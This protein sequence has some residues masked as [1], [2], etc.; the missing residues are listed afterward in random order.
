MTKL[1][2][3]M[4]ALERGAGKKRQFKILEEH[5]DRH[6]STLSEPRLDAI[7]ALLLSETI[8]RV[9]AEAQVKRLVSQIKLERG[10]RK[11]VFN[12]GNYRVLDRFFKSQYDSRDVIDP[13][14]AYSDFRR[15]VEAVGDLPITSSSQDELQKALKPLKGN[16]HRRVVA[17]LNSILK[18][19]KREIRLR[20]AKPDA[21]IVHFLDEHEL[22]KIHNYMEPDLRVLAHV[23]FHTGARLGEAF[24][25]TPQS[26]RPD[27]SIWIDSQIDKK[28]IRRATKN[29]KPRKSYV[30]PGGDKWVDVWLKDCPEVKRTRTALAQ[31]FRRICFKVLKRDLTLHDLRHSYAIYLIGRGI[32]LSLVSQAIGDSI[33]VCERYYSGFV[34]SDEGIK[35][36]KRILTK[37]EDL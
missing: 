9:E 21:D 26:L 3:R 25:I 1:R 8:D 20:P 14:S 34:I 17:R 23:L 36:I 30:L 15:A 33:L 13:D 27:G 5:P 19:L 37:P 29:R 11:P 22:A 7:N 35:T 10:E 4:P 32:S 12:R 18:W 31:S 2:I 16:K 6:F 28:G 24:A